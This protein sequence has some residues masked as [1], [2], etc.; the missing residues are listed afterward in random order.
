MNDNEHSTDDRSPHA[1]RRW[2]DVLMHRWPTALG[3]LCPYDVC[4][5]ELTT[6]LTTRRR[7][8]TTDSFV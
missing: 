3:I 2:I 6:I 7:G 4:H 1:H 5:V 8:S